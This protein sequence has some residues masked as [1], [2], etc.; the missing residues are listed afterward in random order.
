[1]PVPVLRDGWNKAT[2]DGVL[3][4]ERKITWGE[5]ARHKQGN[6]AELGQHLAAANRQWIGD[7]NT[8][9]RAELEQRQRAAAAL[10]Q[11][12]AATKPVVT[13]CNRMGNFASC[14]TY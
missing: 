14:T 2:A 1:M 13:S 7:Q 6:V 8:A 4:V 9:H 3:L 10:L 5:W 11:W 12:Y